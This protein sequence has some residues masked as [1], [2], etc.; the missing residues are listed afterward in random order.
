MLRLMFVC[1]HPSLTPEAQTTLTLRL[2][3]G[4]SAREIA[5]AY[6]TTESTV[7]Q[8]LVR[9]KK[10]LA[11]VGAALEEPDGTERAERL[12]TVLG[13]IYLLFNEGYAA[14]A[15]P[16]WARPALCAEALRVGRILVVPGAGPRRGPR[17]ARPDGAAVLPPGGPGRSR[18]GAGAAGRPGPDALGRRTA[19]PRSAQPEPRPRP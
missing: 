9:A 6:L 18:R 14:T 17:T 5:R 11:T 8:R 13:V 3:A 12:D 10:T 15:G 1:C 19:R 16:D 7:A 4:L 2:V